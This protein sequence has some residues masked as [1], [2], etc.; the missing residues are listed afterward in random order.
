MNLLLHGRVISHYK[1]DAIGI[2]DKESADRA[3]NVGRAHPFDLGR[4]EYDFASLTFMSTVKEQQ[5]IL[6]LY[7]EEDYFKGTL[8][9]IN[10]RDK[11]A[12]DEV[13]PAALRA[14]FA[15]GREHDISEF[16]EALG[17]PLIDAYERKTDEL[18]ECVVHELALVNETISDFRAVAAARYPK[19]TI[20]DIDIPDEG[21]AP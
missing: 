1:K 13:D 7:E 11:L 12:Y 2:Y 10:I 6:K 21:D 9:A 8:R 17:A 16:R 15:D 18:V 14:G 4:Y 20:I 5:A 3:F 19:A